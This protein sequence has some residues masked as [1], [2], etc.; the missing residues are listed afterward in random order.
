MGARDLRPVF[1]GHDSASGRFPGALAPRPSHP[2][3]IAETLRREL[4]E[5][6]RETI[7]GMR[8]RFGEFELKSTVSMGIAAYPGNGL[9]PAELLRAADE[10][11]Y[12][13]KDSG[14]DRVVISETRRQA[15]YLGTGK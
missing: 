13:A 14:R 10:A 3:E 15:G 8:V 4:A 9:A 5:S 1:P 11:L 6:W 7:G 2:R 12:R